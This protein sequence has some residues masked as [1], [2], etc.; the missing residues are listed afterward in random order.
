[1]DDLLIIQSASRRTKIK[2]KKLQTTNYK[3]QTN[4]GFTLIEV[5]IASYIF[6]LVVMA[7]TAIFSSSVGAKM[8]AS[9][10][11]TTQ[12]E[13]RYAMEKIVKTIRD[14]QIKGFQ[15]SGSI[16]LLC[17]TS[18][19]LCDESSAIYRISWS[20]F[21]DRRIWFE[22]NPADPSHP[23]AGLTSTNVDVTD[24]QF[25]GYWPGPGS[26]RQPWITILMTVENA[27]GERVIEKDT[28]TLR[29]TVSLRTYGYKYYDYE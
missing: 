19:V 5:L 3:L 15:T 1:M 9:A 24:L 6:L 11:W 8:K 17:S 20:E 4:R 27:S 14:E 16:L 7:G 28:L 13:T 18:S 21:G 23:M 29:T 22:E 12:Q 25:D 26:D 2:M 10:F